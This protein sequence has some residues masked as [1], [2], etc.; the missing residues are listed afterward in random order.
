MLMLMERTN[1]LYKSFLQ[2]LEV[3]VIFLFHSIFFSF[4]KIES[5]AKLLPLPKIIYNKIFSS[6][7][8]F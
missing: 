6:L 1:I 3:N 8:I 4:L 7:M 2:A 5:V